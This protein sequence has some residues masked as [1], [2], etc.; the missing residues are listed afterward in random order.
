M[1]DLTEMLDSY[2]EELDPDRRRSIYSEYLAAGGSSD[3]VADYRKALFEY[4]LCMV[5]AAE[6][7]LA[8]RLE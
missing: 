8:D 1:A 4:R 7:A 6:A 2:Y 5:D 3:P